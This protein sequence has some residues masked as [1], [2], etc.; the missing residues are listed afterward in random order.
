MLRRRLIAAVVCTLALV[1]GQAPPSGAA[2]SASQCSA[3][4]FNGD[5]RLGP[6]DL[7]AEGSVGLE[8]RNYDRFA[9]LTPQQFIATYW[10]PTA[11]GGQGGY[12]FPPANGFL[13]NPSGQPVHATMTLRAG[14]EL[15]RFGSEFG[16]FLAPAG[17]P[18]SSRA[19]P[20]QSL[21]NA[22]NPGGCNYNLYKV[23]HD[24]NVDGGPIAPAFGQPGHG[25]Q[26]F[27]VGTLVPGAPDRLN[28]KWLI[29]NG[30]LA[31]CVLVV[32]Q[33]YTCG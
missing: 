12:R 30:F 29:D 17:S 1:V 7:A 32:S 10:D 9:G 18:Y 24:F 11:N 13:L 25:L 3:E 22:T 33:P 16:A 19:L 14:L 2:T 26:Y 4:D 8:L 23:V 31:R 28:V 15:D 6:K 27:L 21:D 20:P 5:A